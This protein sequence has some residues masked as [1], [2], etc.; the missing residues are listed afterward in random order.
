MSVRYSAFCEVTVVRCFI[1]VNQLA[2]F[3]FE[4]ILLDSIENNRTA[5]RF[6]DC[7]NDRDLSK[8]LEAL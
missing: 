1:F 8:G 4:F 5:S 7:W 2:L 3:Q 6:D